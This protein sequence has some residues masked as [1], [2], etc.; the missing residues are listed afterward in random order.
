QSWYT[1]KIGSMGVNSR[2]YPLRENSPLWLVFPSSSRSSGSGPESSSHSL[3]LT[4]TAGF[5]PHISFPSTP[6]ACC[7][8][9]SE[10]PKRAKA[11]MKYFICHFTIFQFRIYTYY[12][13]HRSLKIHRSSYSSKH[14][15]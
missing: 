11:R 8:M 14:C 4:P 2:S 13:S 12:S 10:H 3:T 15:L 6:T 1:L 9:A 7:L 5:W